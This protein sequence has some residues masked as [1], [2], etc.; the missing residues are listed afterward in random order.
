MYYRWILGCCFPT[1]RCL[2]TFG[3]VFLVSVI[4]RCAALTVSR[5]AIG[6]F[7]EV[8]C[9]S[10]CYINI[11]GMY[12][13]KVF[14][15]S[16]P[17]LYC[18]NNFKACYWRVLGNT[19]RYCVA[20]TH[21]G[22][23][24]RNIGWCSPS[25]CCL[26]TFGMCYWSVLGWCCLPLCSFSNLRMCYWRVLTSR[27]PSLCCVNTFGMCYCRVTGW[28]IPSLCCFTTLGT[29]IVNSPVLFPSLCCIDSFPA[30]FVNKCWIAVYHGVWMIRSTAGC[31]W[32]S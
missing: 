32:R 11:F 4:L 8:A 6:E 27:C 30:L 29:L 2:S 17:A 31:T 14:E 28:Y 18:V 21:S 10:L 25:L 13:L 16:C 24:W 12:F 5:C 15:C 26:N 3:C 22:C 23:Y 7:S 19:V 20:L 9:P 1:L